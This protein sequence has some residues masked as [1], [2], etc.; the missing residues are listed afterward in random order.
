MTPSWLYGGEDPPD[1]FACPGCD[2]ELD[3]ETDACPS[4]AEDF[5]DREPLD[6]LD[7]EDPYDWTPE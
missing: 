6:P 1:T 5:A 7:R 4:C 2:S 3:A